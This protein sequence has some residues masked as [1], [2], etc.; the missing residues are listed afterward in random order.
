MCGSRI[1][2]W[3]PDLDKMKTADLTKLVAVSFVSELYRVLLRCYIGL[4][5]QAYTLLKS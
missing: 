4:W 1:K 2:R 5:P 3:V